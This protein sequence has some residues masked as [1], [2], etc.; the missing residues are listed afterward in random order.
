MASE[1]AGAARLKPRDGSDAVGSLINK[2][3]PL[4]RR[5]PPD[6]RMGSRPPAETPPRQDTS[7]AS[8]AVPVPP[9]ESRRLVRE[10]FSPEP[11]P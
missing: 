10:L 7:E 1:K 8:L 3:L 9:P 11:G 2:H 5:L 6:E 4:L